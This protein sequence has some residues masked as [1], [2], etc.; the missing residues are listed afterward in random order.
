MFFLYAGTQCDYILPQNDNKMC[1]L[2]RMKYKAYNRMY[3][4]LTTPIS[5][6]DPK[7]TN[8]DVIFPTLNQ[9]TQTVLTRVMMDQFTSHFFNVYF[10]GMLKRNN[11]TEAYA[12]KAF[13][14][15]SFDKIEDYFSVYEYFIASLKVG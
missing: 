8:L 5:P 10:Y 14:Q 4:K 15:L 7:R 9:K 2:I 11:A 6:N 3:Y 13:K 12:Q 1:K